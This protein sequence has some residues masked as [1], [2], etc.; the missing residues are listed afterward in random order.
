MGLFISI[1]TFVILRNVLLENSVGALGIYFYALHFQMGHMPETMKRQKHY[2]GN[3]T[4]NLV[5]FQDHCN[6]Q[7]PNCDD[8]CE[9]NSQFISSFILY[10]C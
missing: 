2:R 3:A 9:V 10:F 6:E 8:I 7:T 1:L 5:P 4:K